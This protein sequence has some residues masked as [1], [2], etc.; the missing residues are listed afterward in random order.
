MSLPGDDAS[1][2][3]TEEVYSPSSATDDTLAD[4]LLEDEA[5]GRAEQAY[6]RK[7]ET[8]KGP[9][10]I[11]WIQET[12]ARYYQ[13][14]LQ[15]RQERR[16]ME[17]EERELRRIETARQERE[18]ARQEK[19]TALKEK[20]TALKE[21]ELEDREKQ[22]EHELRME[23]A[24]RD[25]AAGA[26]LSRALRRDPYEELLTVTNRYQSFNDV[27]RFLDHLDKW[28]RHLN[29]S[30]Q[31]KVRVLRVKLE[32]AFASALEYVPEHKLDDYEALKE[33]ILLAGQ[34]NA[35][36]VRKLY[37]QCHPEAEETAR[38]FAHRKMRLLNTWLARAKVP[39]DLQKVKEYLIWSDIERRIEPSLIPAGL[40]T[41]ESGKSLDE[42][43]CRLD[44][45][46]SNRLS[47]RKFAQLMTQPF[48]HQKNG[49]QN[50]K[51]HQKKNGNG[52]GNNGNGNGHQQQS[53]GQATSQTPST[54]S[55]NQSQV[56]S[57]TAQTSGNGQWKRSNGN[58]KH[59]NGANGRGPGKPPARAL[60][61]MTI[62]DGDT[63]D[64][65]VE[66]LAFSCL[67]FPG[68]EAVPTC[69]GTINGTA[70]VVV[71]DTGAQGLFVDNRY[72]TKDQYTGKSVW[73]Q[74]PEGQPVRRPVAHINLDCEFYDGRAPAVAL[75]APPQPLYLGRVRSLRPM[76][77]S[78]AYDRA[79]SMWNAPEVITNVPLKQQSNHQPPSGEHLLTE[80]GS[81]QVED[82]EMLKAPD[83]TEQE[84]S[85]LDHGVKTSGRRR[86]RRRST[87]SR[88][89][90][91]KKVAVVKDAN[92][93]Q[94]TP[95]LQSAEVADCTACPISANDCQ[96]S[97]EIT[98]GQLATPDSEGEI[99][100]PC[101]EVMLSEACPPSQAMTHSHRSAISESRVVIEDTASKSQEAA[102]LGRNLSQKMISLAISGNE[103]MTPGYTS[104]PQELILLDHLTVHLVNSGKTEEA[105]AL[106]KLLHCTQQLQ[107][108][109]PQYRHTISDVTQ[110]AVGRQS[111]GSTHQGRVQGH[112][113]ESELCIS[114]S[115]TTRAPIHPEEAREN[116]RKEH[117]DL[118]ID[119]RREANSSSQLGTFFSREASP[120]LKDDNRRLSQDQQDE[121]KHLSTTP[122]AYKDFQM[123]VVF[124]R[125]SFPPMRECQD[126]EVS[127]V[128]HLMEALKEKPRDVLADLRQVLKE[129]P[130]SNAAWEIHVS[131]E[132][133]EPLMNK[134]TSSHL[135][136]K[137]SEDD[138]KNR[139]SQGPVKRSFILRR[140]PVAAQEEK[141]VHHP[142]P[143]S[144][145]NPQRPLQLIINF[146]IINQC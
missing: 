10:K 131:T 58:G 53:Q 6:K 67:S 26:L 120:A 74:F 51:H 124:K 89:R 93:G 61:G 105:E 27:Q 49:H 112:R 16:R 99:K 114:Q 20:E 117:Q 81:P 47:D 48:C 96:E 146:V 59:K 2:E 145:K 91:R 60:S 125:N 79:I 126:K 109:P 115:K 13:A 55:T 30:D 23:T 56:E 25:P 136:Q 54:S 139:H 72:V 76:F 118:S 100:Q 116:I 103:A 119:S 77:K 17:N 123:P 143:H 95:A 45:I 97:L 21:K 12:A 42:A 82:A 71:L 40:C 88:S 140:S 90:R 84:P 107:V 35:H 66:P 121:R 78:E 14:L 70:A 19:E 113:Q 32:G 9:G 73:V 92:A 36:A 44:S 34:L 129:E 33:A 127:P 24:R 46:I 98:R 101:Q 3:R 144:V 75:E 128:F 8:L 104:T 37:E 15:E 31:D 80:T 69:H 85:P 29:A 102:P 43:A 133:V 11:K 110:C 122:L 64:Q 50:T 111:D 62:E 108:H 86:R 138:F 130:G 4:V 1:Q 28:F 87:L 137:A 39:Q 22:R 38:D 41:L 132:D 57:Q 141:E 5:Y 63:D 142:L 134:D 106:I 65:E 7:G 18:T 68:A 83:S 94:V 52:N 135:L